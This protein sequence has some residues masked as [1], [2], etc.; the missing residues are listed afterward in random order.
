MIQRIQSVYLLLG[1]LSL[2]FL[3]LFGSVWESQAAALFVWFVPAVA[4]VGAATVLTALAAIFM[5]GNRS[6]QVKTVLAAQVMTLGLMVVLFGGLFL[7][8]DFEAMQAPGADVW[9]VFVLLLP[10]ATYILFYLARRS[11]QRDIDLVKSIDR[12]R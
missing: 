10:V 5:Y 6:K 1:A 9:N 12:L 8:G 3:G 4:I 11:I 7:A 2:A